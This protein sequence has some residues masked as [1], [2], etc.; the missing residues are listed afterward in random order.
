MS[1]R[2]T[3][4]RSAS[5]HQTKSVPREPREGRSD[6]HEAKQDQV[7]LGKR[8]KSAFRDIFKKDPVDDSQFERISDR[9]WTDEY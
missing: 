6:H 9:H 5:H 4:N 3:R 1:S 2:A 7:G 8:F